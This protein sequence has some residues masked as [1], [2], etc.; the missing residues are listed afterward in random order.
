MNCWPCYYTRFCACEEVKGKF[1]LINIQITCTNLNMKSQGS[2]SLP[3]PI[4]TQQ[5]NP[6]ILNHLK[7]LIENLEPI[8]KYDQWPQR[9]FK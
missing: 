8:V 3:K 6:K 5:I 9:E 4:I 7:S 1:S 2:E